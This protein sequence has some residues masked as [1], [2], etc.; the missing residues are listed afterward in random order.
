MKALIVSDNHGRD[1]ELYELIDMYDGEID[2][3]LHC[4]D[5][6]FQPSDPVFETFNAVRGNVDWGIF[7]NVQVNEL[8]GVTIVHTHGHLYGVNSGVDDLYDLAEEYG[9][10][11]VFYG[12]THIPAVDELGGKYF[13][14]PGSLNFPRGHMQIGSYA[15]LELGAE[16]R[17]D[18]YTNEHDWIP[19]LSQTINI[20]AEDE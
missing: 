17:I 6:E 9:A 12:H 2:L 1:A 18:F 14:N 13:I 15:V 11:I 5:S 7:P 19:E 8:G 3:W 20:I 4:G 16:S 10:E